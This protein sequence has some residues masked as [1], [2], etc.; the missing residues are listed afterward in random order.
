ME[1][2][3]KV[4]EEYYIEFTDEELA[5]LNLKKGDKV[6]FEI[7]EKTKE[8]KL[9]PFASIELDL[10]DFDRENLEFL[11]SESIEKDISVNDVIREVIDKAVE[12]YKNEE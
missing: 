3:V 8:V 6:S 9:I 10:K 11:I 7:D 5:Q 2:S 12:R 1:K 4:K